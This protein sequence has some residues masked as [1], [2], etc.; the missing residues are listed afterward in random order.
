[1]VKT[2]DILGKWDKPVLVLPGKGRIDPGPFFDDDGKVYLVYA[3]AATRAGMNSVMILTELNAD[4]TQ[5]VGQESLIFD[6]NDGI[7]HTVE[8]VNFIK[9]MAGITYWRLPVARL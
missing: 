3:W 8:G 9:K 2:K 4:G 6:G 7:N 1:M 5:V